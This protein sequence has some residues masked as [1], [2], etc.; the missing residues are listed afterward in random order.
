MGFLA[1]VCQWPTDILKSC[2]ILIPSQKVFSHYY[3][4][5]CI[6]GLFDGIVLISPMFT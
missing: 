3:T 6:A 2:K 4:V 1:L 5:V